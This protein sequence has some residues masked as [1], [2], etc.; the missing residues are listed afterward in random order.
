MIQEASP[1]YWIAVLAVTVALTVVLTIVWL[2]SPTDQ[3]RDRDV[4]REEEEK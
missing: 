4:R 1:L 2:D 3:E